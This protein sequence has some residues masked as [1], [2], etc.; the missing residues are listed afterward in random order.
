[1]TT[2]R[3]ED[4]PTVET[5][6]RAA[7]TDDQPE[8][9]TADERAADE[10][11]ADED[12]RS[13][14]GSL[15]TASS[16]ESRPSPVPRTA[17][18]PN[19]DR[20]DAG[21]DPAPP[22]EEWQR[23]VSAGTLP[24]WQRAYGDVDAATETIDHPAAAPTDPLVQAGNGVGVD[25]PS[26]PSPGSRAAEATAEAAEA[27]IGE[28]G[29][30]EAASAQPEAPAEPLVGAPPEGPAQPTAPVPPVPSVGGTSPATGPLPVS[31]GRAR[32]PRQASLQLKRVDPWS[33]LKLALVLAAVTFFV[34]LVAVGVLYG[35]MDGMG[36][37]DRLN[38]TYSDLVS[39]DQ[40]GGGVLINA[41]RVFGAAAIIGAINSVLLAVAVTVGAFVYNVAADLVGGIELTLSERD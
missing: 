29:T 33:V 23:A 20:P 3:P 10:R 16:S 6:E 34:W 24:P 9:S 7:A 41:G 35:V 25:R 22:A 2:Q 21:K 26:A 40:A 4:N 13:G 30:A 18:E 11:A 38:G 17:E 15:S 14:N 37:W 12:G 8:A 1:V 36:V 19:G 27:A 39:P 32:P 5:D 31:R 28:A